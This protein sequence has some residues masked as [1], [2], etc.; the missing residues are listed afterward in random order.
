M[1]R[2]SLTHESNIIEQK[3]LAWDQAYAKYKMFFAGLVFATLSFIGTH[4]IS[5]SNFILKILECASLVLLLVSGLVLL[6]HLAQHLGNLYNFKNK[7]F[8]LVMDERTYWFPFI[9]GMILLVLNR[10]FLLF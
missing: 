6:F 10:C 8:L 1:S 2:D 9:L 4:S 7:F 5:T 3:S